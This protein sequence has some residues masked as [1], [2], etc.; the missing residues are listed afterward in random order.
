MK[1]I[2]NYLKNN[3]LKILTVYMF[4][5]PFIDM[6]TGVSLTKLNNSFVIGLALRLLFMIYTVY[7]TIFLTNQKKKYYI[8]YYSLILLYIIAFS[9]NILYLKGFNPFS[10][11]LKNTLK[12]FYFPIILV[13]LIPILKDN[14][15]E[16]N[17]NNFKILFIIYTLG[18]LIPNFLGIG[19]STYA[20]TKKGSIG[21]FYTANEIGAI[22]SILMIFYIN[23]L[24]SKRKYLKLIIS[25][26]LITY[27]FTSIGT[28]GPLILYLL[29]IFYFFIKYIKELIQK[30]KYKLISI[31]VTSFI[32]LLI[33]FVLLIPK[34]NFYKNIVVHLEF[35]Q[36]YNVN[37]FINNK[38][39]IDHMIFSE[40][41]SFLKNTHQ[42]Y[43][44]SYL[45][46]KLLGIGYISNYAT[47]DIVMKMVEMDFFDIFYRHGIIGF[48]IYI[49]SLGYILFNI[50]KKKKEVYYISIIF[51]L[52][53]AFITGHVLI[54]P[55]VSIY[56][57]L[58]INLLY[59]EN[60][61]RTV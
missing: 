23:D 56:V 47:D 41:L 12:T 17:N 33:T 39:A 5:Q 14:R 9:I 38:N 44:K 45:S 42:I 24:Y 46:E 43:E 49:S 34:T 15:K 25:I 20:I 48:I 54:A 61:G 7:Y 29:L 27:L 50:I 35:W 59:N 30:K 21:F 13:S 31:I 53:L 18:V 37:D 57:A 10:Y 58:L 40:R 2:N 22:L 6:I 19:L 3:S 51:S 60:S 8:I 16:F 52:L 26:I 1:K 11:E 28:K 4:M 36:I 32:V 55:A